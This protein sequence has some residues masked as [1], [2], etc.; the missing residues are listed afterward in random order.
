[1]PRVEGP[2]ELLENVNENDYK[3]DLLGDFGV[4][5]TFNVADLSPYL[6]DD[7]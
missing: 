5:A 1:M 3:V 7:S 6:P 4:L 2:F